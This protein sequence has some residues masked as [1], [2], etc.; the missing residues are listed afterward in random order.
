VVAVSLNI[1]IVLIAYTEDAYKLA[2][3]LLVNIKLSFLVFYFR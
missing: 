2:V 3:F 1:L